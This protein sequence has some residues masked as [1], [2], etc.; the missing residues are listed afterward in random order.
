MKTTQV[1][2]AYAV[3]VIVFAFVHASAQAISPTYPQ[4][5]ISPAEPSQNDSVKLW[6]ILGQAASTCIP[7]YTSSFKVA[8]TSNFV[9]VRAPCAQNFVISLTYAENPP[10][11]LGRPCLALAT[12]YGPQFAFGKLAVGNYTVVD[13]TTKGTTVATFAVTEKI[14]PYYNIAGTVLQDAGVIAPSVSIPGAT[15]YLKTA[16]PLPMVSG[17]PLYTIV[18]S[19]TTDA[20]GAFTF[21]RLSPAGYDLGFVAAGFQARD[22]SITVPPDTS[23]TVAM[24]PTNAKCA[25][26]GFVTK[27]MQCGSGLPVP[28]PIAPVAGCSITVSLPVLVMPFAK[29]SAVIAGPQYTAVTNGSGQYVIDSI[30]VTYADRS[31]M[32]AA[33]KT[34]FV[35]GSSAATLLANSTVTVNF[36]LL[37][38]YVNTETTTVDDVQ[39]IVAT[40]KPWYYRGAGIKARYTVNNNSIAKVVF[41]FSSGCQFDMVAMAPP[42]DTVTWY[43]RLLACTM[44]ATQ[45]TLAPGESKSMDFPVFTDDD[46]ASSLAITARL[47]GYGKSASTLIVPISGVVDP[48]APVSRRTSESKKSVI[49]YSA[50][51]KT[52]S[53]NIAKSQYVSVSAYVVSGQ[54]ISQLSTKKYLTAGTHA[55][56]LTD[57]SLSNGIIIFRVEG[58]GFS[59]VKRVNLIE[60]R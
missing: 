47:I 13:S 23:V 52:L 33:S 3:A 25:I 41:D 4:P 46:T 36:A 32:V 12:D 28:C 27:D 10:L 20:N 17:L 2:G 44:M 37:P 57:A 53:L 5:V 6:L 30:P 14:A 39:F 15:V 1:F 35:Q 55:I 40:E 7:T 43:G 29:Q 8:Q 21:S 42:R 49:S 54:K 51:T 38:S 11:P 45:I 26:T 16:G 31:V 56:R 60:G 18:D 50:A 58:E 48:V 19:T 59:A 34:G 22:Q 24:L 9:C